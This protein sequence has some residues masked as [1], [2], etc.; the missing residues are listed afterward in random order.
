MRSALYFAY[1]SNMC[2]SRLVKRVPS[3]VSVAVGYLQGHRLAFHKRSKDGSRKGDVAF[4]GSHDDCVWGVVFRVA[5]GD[6]PD[7][8]AVEGRGYGYERKDVAIVTSGGNVEA[9]THYA[10]TTDPT[11]VPYSWYLRFYVLGA[12]EHGLP[13]DYTAMLQGVASIEDPDRE[14]DANN[15]AIEE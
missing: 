14:R 12:R 6:I 11:L 1:G 10:T 3:A 7:L 13:A 5:A 2:S 9:F 15:R 8:D 4:T